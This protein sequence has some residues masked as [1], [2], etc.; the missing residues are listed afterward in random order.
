MN[1]LHEIARARRGDGRIYR[2]L[3]TLFVVSHMRGFTTLL[4]HLLGSHPEVSGYFE[5]HSS[6]HDLHDLIR[7]R[8]TLDDADGLSGDEKWIVDKVLGCDLTISDAVL[9]REDVTL[10]FSLRRPLATLK[11]MIATR[12]RYGWRM[13]RR[14]TTEYYFTRL[15]Q[16]ADFARRA[17]GGFYLDA[18]AIV[19]RT[20]PTLDGLSRALN[21]APPLQAD[22]TIHSMTGKSGY[23]CPSDY[24]RQGRIVR[25]RERYEDI[26]IDPE[27]LARAERAYR[28]CRDILLANC[29]AVSL[30]ETGD[31]H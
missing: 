1:R 15:A 22:F 11:S 20:G 12:E 31:E 26:E 5:T 14:R 21:L 23:G 28:E 29:T 24:I 4:T 17:P 13:D 7:L 30:L 25:D 8:A 6:Y 2:D 9:R 10:L 3:D 16:I 19:E 18:E 27:L